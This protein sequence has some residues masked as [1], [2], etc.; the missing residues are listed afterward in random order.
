MGQSSE[1]NSLSELSPSKA[2]KPDPIWT[3]EVNA[4]FLQA[5]KQ[6]GGALSS[7]PSAVSSAL[8]PLR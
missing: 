1:S 6:C 2:A 8:H 7:T 3:P 4:K 5:V